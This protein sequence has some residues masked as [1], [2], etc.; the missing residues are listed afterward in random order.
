[1]TRFALPSALVSG[2]LA[3]GLVLAAPSVHALGPLD[4]ELAAKGGYGAQTNSGA[5]T[6]PFG[7]GI[8]GRAGVAIFGLYGGVNL[9]YYLGGSQNAPDGSSV[10]QHSLMYGFE[11][12]YGFKLLDLLTVR[13]QIGLGNF[14]YTA[15]STTWNTLYVEPGVT[16]FLSLGGFL[17]GADAGI[18]VLPGFN[19]G[20]P[21]GTPGP[22]LTLH[23]QLGWKF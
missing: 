7:G 23:G 22:A 6:G 14:A 3:A 13:G 16:A 19:P 1:M 5:G 8:G 20:G 12:G 4:I 9:L 17:V 18:V 21:L 10:S 2:L 15:A 11:G